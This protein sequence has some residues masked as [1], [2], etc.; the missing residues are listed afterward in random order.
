MS[1]RRVADKVCIVTGAAQ[2]IGEAIGRGLVKEGACVT[3][4][5]LNVEKAE[6]VAADIRKGGGRAIAFKV[7]V[8][9]RDQ[10]KSLIQRT[11]DEFGQLNVMFN[12]AGV[13]K[14]QN[15]LET[16]ED[17]WDFIMRINGLGVLIGIQ[18]AAKQMISQRRGG[19]IVNTA[20]VVGRQG[21]ANVAPYCASKSAVISLTQSAARDLAKNHITVNGFSPGVVATPLWD[22]L[23]KQLMELGESSK[24][25]EAIQNFS[26]NILMGR[27]ATPQ[28]IVPTALFLASADS[29]YVTGQ[30]MAIDG[31]QILV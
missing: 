1:T 4:A 19:K 16:T 21:F 25:G 22:Q 17:N 14:P 18:E 24:P 27:P 12:N 2:G 13:N 20:S 15:F 30:I 23:D 9:K 10:M 26:A 6:A 28:D 7:D 29:D 11:V 31:G 8:S 5:D 3:F